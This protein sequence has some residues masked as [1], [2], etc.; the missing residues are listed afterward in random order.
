MR[1]VGNHPSDSTPS[2]LR[3]AE[4]VTQ[5]SVLD[6]LADDA[7]RDEFARC[8]GLLCLDCRAGRPVEFDGN[9]GT[10]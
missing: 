8:C 5:R 7:R 3:P 4:P 9:N 2:A 1:D 10:W 6:A